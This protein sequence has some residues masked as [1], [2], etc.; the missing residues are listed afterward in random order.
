MAEIFR[1]DNPPTGG[2]SSAAD[3]KNFYGAEIDSTSFVTKENIFFLFRNHFFE[4]KFNLICIFFFLGGR[5]SD[6]PKSTPTASL[7]S[8]QCGGVVSKIN[9]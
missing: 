2:H 1:G 5:V 6:P 8:V 4:G 7:L 3:S 9:T